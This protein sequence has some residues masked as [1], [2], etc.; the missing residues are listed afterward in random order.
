MGIRINVL[1]GRVMSGK[2]ELAAGL[3]ALFDVE[4]VKTHRLIRELTDARS[5]RKNL[6]QA[7]E[8][9]DRS[10]HGEWVSRELSKIVAAKHLNESLRSVDQWILVD[11]VRIPE[12][13]QH[14]RQS[15]GLRV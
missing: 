9:L 13:I 14:I 3:Q 5:D 11:S 10:T 7:G 12:Q 4:L 8:A 2:S 1:S 15:F 6:Q